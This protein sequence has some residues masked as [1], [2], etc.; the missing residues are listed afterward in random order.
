MV[1]YPQWHHDR[2]TYRIYQKKEKR[3]PPSNL[4]VTLKS[5]LPFDIPQMLQTCSLT[6]ENRGQHLQEHYS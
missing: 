5:H 6:Q 2:N 4:Q 3:P 1:F